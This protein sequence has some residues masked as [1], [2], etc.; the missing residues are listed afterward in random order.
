[1]KSHRPEAAERALKERDRIW[2]MYIRARRLRREEMYREYPDLRDFAQAVSR[3]GPEDAAAMLSY[4]R[5]CSHGWLAT[6][7]GQVRAE[8]LALVDERIQRIRVRSGAA[9]FDDPLPG[10]GDDVFRLVKQELT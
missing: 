2:R 5:E 8:A 1:M 10:D 4:V 3:F 9:P 6:A 7:E